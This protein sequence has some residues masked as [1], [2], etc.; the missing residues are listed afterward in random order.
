MTSLNIISI[1]IIDHFT[2]QQG[3]F[4]LIDW[5]LAENYLAYSDYENWRYAN[6]KYVDEKIQLEKKSIEIMV[7]ETQNHC[8]SLGLVS[9]PQIYHCWNTNSNQTLK[10]S[11]SSMIN[12]QLM[13]RWIRPQDV[14]QLDLFMDNSAQMAE[15][16]V[17]NA[18]ADRQ[19][20]SAQQALTKLQQVDQN[21]KQLGAYQDLVNYGLHMTTNHLIEQQSLIAEFAGLKNEVVPLA[22]DTLASQARDYLSFAWQRLAKNMQN[23]AFDPLNPEL[24]QSF[25]LMQ[26]PDMD[27]TIACLEKNAQLFDEYCLLKRLVDCY[28][29]AHQQEK[30]LLGWC[31][32]LEMDISETLTSIQHDDGE[33]Y[34]LW[35]DYWEECENWPDDLFAAYVLIKKPMLVH[36]SDE[37]NLLTDQVNLTVVELLKVKINGDDEISQRKALQQLSPQLLGLYLKNT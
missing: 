1:N 26:I 34:Q 2:S 30:C 25:A 37:I 22:R 18:L 3:N 6:V 31:K 21:C 4:C 5:L 7:T 28:W 27:A 14:P 12:Q 33:I 20:E 8:R 24:H 13:Q 32:L 10:A 9:E 16:D 11:A 15:Y 19:F 36:F 29:L 17:I 23:L 35:Q